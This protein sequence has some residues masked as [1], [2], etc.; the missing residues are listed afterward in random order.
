MTRQVALR[1]VHRLEQELESCIQQ[2]RTIDSTTSEA[3]A[4]HPAFLRMRAAVQ[5][6]MVC[7]AIIV[8]TPAV[9][10]LISRSLPSTAGVVARPAQRGARYSRARDGQEA[11]GVFRA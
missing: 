4:R 10:M 5:Q 2:L 1:N 3:V 8:L 6:K 11:D 9:L 7:N